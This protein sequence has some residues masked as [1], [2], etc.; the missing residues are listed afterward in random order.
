MIGNT[1]KA[2]SLRA[3]VIKA[4]AQA[5]KAEPKDD[6]VEYEV[7]IVCNLITLAPFVKYVYSLTHKSVK[8][9]NIYNH[10]FLHKRPLFC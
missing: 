6:L 4:K 5:N 7:G 9:N 8:V 3:K 10:Y 2:L 1:N